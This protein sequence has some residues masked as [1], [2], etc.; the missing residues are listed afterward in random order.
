MS[1]KLTPQEL[2]PVGVSLNRWTTL[3]TAQ[4]VDN[5]WK[6]LC[7][8]ICGTIRSINVG[9]FKSGR[10]KSC[11][12]LTIEKTKESLTSHGLADK[13][14]MYQTWLGMR[15][16]CNNKK[17]VSYRNYGGRGITVCERWNKF[18][19]FYADMGDRPEGLS[20]DRV[21]N[22]RGYSPENCKWSTASEQ[23]SNSRGVHHITHNGHTK[24]ILEWATL[25]NLHPKVLRARLTSY[26]WTVERAL[27]TPPKVTKDKPLKEDKNDTSCE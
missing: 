11:G 1:K 13:H 27:N 22:S 10:S 18:E 26:G 6:I 23:R 15:A 2:P 20:L 24:T 3:A 17:H 25:Y 8:C 19:N 21:D 4:L 12:C 16:R 9:N 5:T 7:K 14:P